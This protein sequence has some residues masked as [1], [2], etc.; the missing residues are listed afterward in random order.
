MNLFWTKHF[1]NAASGEPQR[2]FSNEPLILM[3]FVNRC[4]ALTL[5]LSLLVAS[6]SKE[7]N[8]LQQE[9]LCEIHGLY[10]SVYES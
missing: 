8:E 7:N 9:L 3:H 6:V 1:L 4:S 10:G 2:H 5:Y